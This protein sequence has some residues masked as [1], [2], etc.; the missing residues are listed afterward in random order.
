MQSAGDGFREELNS[1][2][3]LS[4]LWLP[5][6]VIALNL[7]STERIGCQMKQFVWTISGAKCTLS[8]SLS[9]HLWRVRTA[10]YYEGGIDF[11]LFQFR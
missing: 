4:S 3:T 2:Y 1:S 6:S 8:D 5:R 11:L 7:R 9:A 10:I